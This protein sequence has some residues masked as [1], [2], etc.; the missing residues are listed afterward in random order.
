M[1]M[2]VSL[3][4]G[5]IENIEIIL[6][7][8][9]RSKHQVIHLDYIQFLFTKYTSVNLGGEVSLLWTEKLKEP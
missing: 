2:I 7:S 5:I 1:D 3:H 4:I 6:Q 8:A 9:H